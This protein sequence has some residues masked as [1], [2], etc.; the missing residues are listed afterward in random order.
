MSKETFNI[1]RAIQKAGSPDV[2][3]HILIKMDG[4]NL[5]EEEIQLLKDIAELK[6]LNLQR[7]LHIPQYPVYGDRDQEYAD[8]FGLALIETLEG[9]Q[10]YFLKEKVKPLINKL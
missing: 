7:E 2:I 4:R 8:E 9:R 10:L 5:K 3:F 1:G 6:V